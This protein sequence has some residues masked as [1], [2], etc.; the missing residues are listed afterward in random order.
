MRTARRGG[1]GGLSESCCLAEVRQAG[2]HD[3]GIEPVGLAVRSRGEAQ[4]TRRGANMRGKKARVWL[5]VRLV[6]GACALA[7]A[8]SVHLS[9]SSATAEPSRDSLAAEY[10]AEVRPLFQ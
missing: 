2:Y 8:G 5:G 1:T 10:A 3:G 7:A 6:L 9:S 4:G